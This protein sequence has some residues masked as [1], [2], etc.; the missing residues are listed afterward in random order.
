MAISTTKGTET[1]MQPEGGVALSPECKIATYL[2][3]GP[4]DGGSP[5]G[6]A[7]AIDGLSADSNK[8][9]G[10]APKTAGAAAHTGVYFTLAAN[11]LTLT[12]AAAALATTD[13]WDVT[14]MTQL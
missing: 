8:I 3:S 4:T 7:V 2:I 6:F 5:T 10:W 13:Q 12:C 14:I 11:L 9:I 1:K